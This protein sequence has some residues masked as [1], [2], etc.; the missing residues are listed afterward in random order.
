MHMSLHKSCVH[1]H[2]LCRAAW[3]AGAGLG[4]SLSLS[5]ASALEVRGKAGAAKHAQ[6]QTSAQQRSPHNSGCLKWSLA[7]HFA[8]ASLVFASKTREKLVNIM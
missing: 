5:L 7:T 4:V 6:L 8:G 1:V 2:V 3:R